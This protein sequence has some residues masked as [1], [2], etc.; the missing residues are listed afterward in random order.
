MDTNSTDNKI[1]NAVSLLNAIIELKPGGEKRQQQQEAVAV[2]QNALENEKN[3][4]IESPTGAGKTISY[5]IPVIYN[6]SRAVISTAN[7]QLSDQIT[8]IDIPF[9]QKAIK[10]I[11]PEYGFS[12]ALLKGRENY[13]C[14]AKNEELKLLS[15]EADTLFNMTDTESSS[16]SG[17]AAKRA[18]EIRSVQKW[19]E[20]TPTGDRSDAPPVSDETW[21]QLSSTSTECPGKQVCPFGSICFAELAR[22]KA[23]KASVVVTNHAVVGNDLMTDEGSILGERDVYVFDELHELDNYL[24]SAWGTRLTSK[25]LKDA[26]KTF[27][28]L[29]DISN[30][31]VEEVELLSRKFDGVCDSIP[32]G[33]INGSPVLL[34]QLATRLY[35]ASTKAAIEAGKIAKDDSHRES[36]RKTASIV[37][38]KAT[39]LADAT[40][41]LLDD[42]PNT[43]RW[44]SKNEDGN[45]ETVK[46]INAAPLRIGPKLQLALAN[47]DAHMVGTSATIRVG[48][49][50]AIPSHNLA[51]DES[52]VPYETVALSSP[53][54]YKKQALLYIP[55]SSS[56][57]APV[58]A[59]RKEHTEAV[60]KEIVDLV[61]ASDGR[62]LCL[63][64]TSYAATENGKFLRKTFPKMNILVQGEAPA[65]QLVDEFKQDEKSVLVATMGMWHGVDPVGPTCSLVVIDKI[66]FKPMNDP[67]SVAR[68][69]WAEENGRNGFM[70]VYVADANVMLSQGVGRLIRS[71]S[72]RGVVAILDTRL[73]SKTY[74][75]SMLKSL[76]PMTVFQDKNKVLGA[77]QRLSSGLD[78][79]SNNE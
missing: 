10:T 53:F 71:S 21:R 14:Y 19:A 56:F 65:Q 11:A 47:R 37:V 17:N 25:M 58:G 23:R 38:K 51:L 33:V 68:Q 63:F 12:S 34:K 54:D 60:K 5:L 77:L 40:E 36:I 73:I 43:V 4:L 79:P 64:T 78:A 46:A 57:P 67:L 59:D 22:D 1:E 48:G 7:K 35:T 3:L 39:E 69:Q 62:A 31:V 6:R 29:P 76:P 55:A 26:A 27:K 2:I 41:L 70:D 18:S 15:K 9:V 66:P 16:T 28:Q 24:S 49:S 8:K 42:S 72:D 50:F 20:K 75:K 44:V 45:K 13:F 74:G 32:E 30:S 61:K 52:T